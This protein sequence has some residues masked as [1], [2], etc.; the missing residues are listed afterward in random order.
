VRVEKKKKKKNNKNH[1]QLTCTRYR[2]IVI[3][4]ANATQSAKSCRVN[5]YKLK[6]YQGLSSGLGR[7]IRVNNKQ[8]P[9]P[10]PPVRALPLTISNELEIQFPMRCK[11]LPILHRHPRTCRPIEESFVV[12]RVFFFF[13]FFFCFRCS[14]GSLKQKNIKKN[15]FHSKTSTSRMQRS[16]H[17]VNTL[18]QAFKELNN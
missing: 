3:A 11:S 2:R 15:L 1:F 8:P 6:S 14:S 13:F 18:K 7:R 17:I 16:R 4:I 9:P 5:R 10:P 12:S